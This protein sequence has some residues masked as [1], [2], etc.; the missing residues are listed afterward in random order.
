[1]PMPTP[2]AGGMPT[3][4]VPKGPRIFVYELIEGF[5][6]HKFHAIAY[7]P[8]GRP[9]SAYDDTKLAAVGRVKS[10]LGSGR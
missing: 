8:G 7:P 3:V 10:L 5:D 1:M 4:V 9:V 6:G 2:E